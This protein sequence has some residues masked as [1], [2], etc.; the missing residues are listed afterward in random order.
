MRTSIQNNAEVTVSGSKRPFEGAELNLGAEPIHGNRRM[1]NAG[2]RSRAS[3]LLVVAL[4]CLSKTLVTRLSPDICEVR[5]KP[6]RTD[7]AQ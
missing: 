7:M 3:G 1:R 5:K 6:S 4:L 2:A